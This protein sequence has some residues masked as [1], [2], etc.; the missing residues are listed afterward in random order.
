MMKTGMDVDTDED[1]EEAGDGTEKLL[2]QEDID[3]M[4][5]ELDEYMNKWKDEPGNLEHG[6]DLWRKYPTWIF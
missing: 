3:R 6:Q 2:T 4:R 5:Q 1:E